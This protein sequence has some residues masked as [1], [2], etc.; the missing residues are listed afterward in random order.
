MPRSRLTAV[1]APPP[2]SR[3]TAY[4]AA[5]G[6]A[7]REWARAFGAV[8]LR[9]QV[10]QPCRFRPGPTVARAVDTYV[11]PYGNR[12]AR[13]VRTPHPSAWRRAAGAAAF[14]A[15]LRPAPPPA[16]I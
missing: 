5:P 15:C 7:A 10:P 11:N 2:A 8:V 3:P 1:T 13:E 16:A 9:W 4:V 14:L 6:R 12:Y